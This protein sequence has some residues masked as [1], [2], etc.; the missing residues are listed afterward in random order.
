MSL[1]KALEWRYATKK[2]DDT[3]IISDIE[4][5][6]IKAGFNLSASSYGLQPVTM[7]LVHNKKIQK[8]M[9]E[10]SMN[11]KQVY[12]ASHLAIFCVKTSIESK[13]VIEYFERIKAIRKTD[14]KILDS[15]RTHI[16]ET[17]SGKSSD[18]TYLWGA[19]QAYL[20]MGNLLAVCADLHI[21]ACPMEGFDPKKYDDY[22]NLKS[23]GLKSVLIMPMGFRA[24][25]DKFSKMK[26]VRKPISQSVIEIL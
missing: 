1:I 21:D 18:D 2:F 25:D 11:Q 24:E 9:I 4:I 6:K 16:I 10:F 17:F 19:K 14:D 20:A 7:I 12:Q 26:K 3:K 8:K 15:F 22:F 5:K 23:K 13:Y